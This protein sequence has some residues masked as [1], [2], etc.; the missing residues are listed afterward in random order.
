[1]PTG[2]KNQWEVAIKAFAAI[3]EFNEETIYS[4]QQLIKQNPSLL[5]NDDIVSALKSRF[6]ELFAEI[7]A[8]PEIPNT[9]ARTAFIQSLDLNNF[10]EHSFN[11]IKEIGKFESDLIQ[12]EKP[13]A[14]IVLKG[15]QNTGEVALLQAATQFLEPQEFRDAVNSKLSVGATIAKVG[16]SKIR[17]EVTKTLLAFHMEWMAKQESQKPKIC[18]ELGNFLSQSTG[19]FAEAKNALSSEVRQSF[20]ENSQSNAQA[21][22][23]QNQEELGRGR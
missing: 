22:P 1:M 14:D 17:G 15:P 9:L 20:V 2:V 13:F 5:E 10:V 23:Q 16:A 19:L 21:L 8:C 18:E 6:P 3:E 7:P 12:E 11:N 4:L